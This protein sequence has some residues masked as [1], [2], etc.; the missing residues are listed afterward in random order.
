MRTLRFLTLNFWGENGP[1]QERLA[2]VARELGNLKPDVIAMQ[3]VRQVA[4]RI[5]NQAETLAGPLGFSHVFAPSTHWG[6]GDEGLAIISRFPITAHEVRRLPHSTETEGRIVLSAAVDGDSGPFWVHTTHMSFREN[7]GRMREDQVLM[8]DETVVAHKN[9]NPQIL[10][11]DFNTVPLADEIRWLGGLTTLGGRRVHYQDAWDVVNTGAPGY[12]WARANFYT[13]RMGW[14]RADRR[15]DYIF[16][17]TPRRDGRGSVH[18]ARVVLDQPMTLASGEPLFASDHFGVMA[19]IQMAANPP[20]EEPPRVT[21][22]NGDGPP[23][24]GAGKT[25]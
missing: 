13:D 4:G 10:M 1:W 8:L 17:T 23:G 7:E 18:T 19:E 6:G 3:E 16:V 22:T 2:L 9:D 24:T 11:G 20:R 12:T 5:P 25:A 14:L 21:G 15:L